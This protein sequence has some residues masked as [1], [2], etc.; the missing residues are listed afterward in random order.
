M[1]GWPTCAKGYR[2]PPQR[3]PQWKAFTTQV[4]G[5]HRRNRVVSR[6]AQRLASHETP[7]RQPAAADKPVKTDGFGRV[8][9]TRGQKS[10]RP[11]KIR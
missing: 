5:R 2:G 10:A 7:R 4:P 6:G 11:S 9:G 3:R 8:V 1:A